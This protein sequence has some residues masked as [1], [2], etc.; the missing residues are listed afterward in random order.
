MAQPPAAPAGEK[1]ARRDPGNTRRVDGPVTP[2]ARERPPVPPPIGAEEPTS[3]GGRPRIPRW[4][5][6]LI[7]LAIL[8]GWNVVLFLPPGGPPSA[9]IPYSAFVAQ[10]REGNVASVVF[11]D[12]RINGSFVQPVLWPPAAGASAQPSAAAGESGAASPAASTA[13]AAANV[14]APYET[15]S[16][17]V[18]PDGDPALL[19]L[20]E[21]HGVVVSSI[22]TSSMGSVFGAI[23][24]LL[25]TLLPVLL[26]AG[27]FIYSGRQLQRN[28]QGILGFG[29]SNARLYDAERPKVTFADVAGEDEAK[30]ELAE[31]V[32]FLKNPEQVPALG[33]PAAARR[34]AHRSARH[35]Q[36][37]AGANRRRRG[38][39]SRSSASRRPSS[40][41]C[42]WASAPVARP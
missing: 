8:V 30:T 37:A 18:P 39:A 29:K 28:Q 9:E 4:A 20:L 14:P 6:W 22:D 36:D 41:S 3:P 23:L 32:D 33:R 2:P 11:T 13:A 21:Q 27:V 25:G 31:V 19:P 34:P 10:A 24:G 26:L 12:Q 35:R 7:L 42:S 16:T 40:S 38:R 5:Q 1:A 15:F 17:V